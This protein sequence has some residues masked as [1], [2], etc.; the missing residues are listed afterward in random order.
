[1]AKFTLGVPI[2]TPEPAITVDISADQPL[3]VGKH[4]FRL[5]VV[6]DSGNVS[7]PAELVVFVIDTTKPTAILDGPTKVPFMQPF[8][9]SGRKSIDIGGK[10]VKFVWTLVD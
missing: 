6:D 2:E 9:L 10:I 3:G 8:D 5:A 4:L 7:D 1:M